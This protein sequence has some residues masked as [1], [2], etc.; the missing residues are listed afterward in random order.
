[1]NSFSEPNSIDSS[2]VR[3]RVKV[4]VWVSHN[5][6]SEINRVT[7]RVRVRDKTVEFFL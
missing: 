1:M 4:R 5:G 2:V 7:I 6:S 3:V